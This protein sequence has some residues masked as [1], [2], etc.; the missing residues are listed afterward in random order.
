MT[1]HSN[2]S[3]FL[4]SKRLKFVI[5]WEGDPVAAAHAAGYKDTKTAAYRLMKNR[6]VRAEIRRKQTAMTEESGKRLAAQ[7]NFNRS[8]V[9]NRL[10]EI[11]QMGPTETNGN[12]GAQV[13]ASEALAAL[14][15]SKEV[16][17]EEFLT[18]LAN[19]TPDQLRRMVADGEISHPSGDAK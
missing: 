18:E 2:A 8:H 11:A 10:W 13:R 1:Q 17:V 6:L 7:L 15:N 12:A 4:T 3:E 5:A 14:F 19:K 9:L 16:I